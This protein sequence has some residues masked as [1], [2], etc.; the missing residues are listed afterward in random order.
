MFNKKAIERLIKPIFCKTPTDNLHT[1]KVCSRLQENLVGESIAFEEGM[2]IS[3]L[4]H[5]HATMHKYR[6]F[7][8]L[9]DPG[10][11]MLGDWV[12]GYYANYYEL[13]SREDEFLE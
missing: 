7:K 1:Q 8:T 3:D 11:C 10:Y 9:Q 4:M 5:Q 2:S 12:I 13:G 6:D